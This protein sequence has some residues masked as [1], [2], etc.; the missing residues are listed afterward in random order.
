[1]IQ[2][3]GNRQFPA[4]NPLANALVII[5]GAIAIG[6][7]VILGF[8]VFLAIGGILAVLAAIVGIRIW[9]FNRRLRRQ[10]ENV[11]EGQP[12]TDSQVRVIEGEF[13]VVSTERKRTDDD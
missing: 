10:F 1:L 13:E 2:Y 3:H 4:G 8:V 6:V 11:P 12:K 7:S 9:W 5:V